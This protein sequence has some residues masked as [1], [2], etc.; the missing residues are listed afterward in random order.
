MLIVRIANT[1]LN[2]NLKIIN[3][4]LTTRTYSNTPN[5]SDAVRGV[6]INSLVRMIL[7]ADFGFGALPFVSFAPRLARSTSSLR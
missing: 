7:V 6:R 3:I 2:Y 4:I 5:D 1:K